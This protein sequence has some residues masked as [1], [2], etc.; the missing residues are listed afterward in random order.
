MKRL[1]AILLFVCILPICAFADGFGL[2][3]PEFI[4]NYN[5]RSSDKPIED[6]RNGEIFGTEDRQYIRLK[7][8]DGVEIFLQYLNSVDSELTGIVIMQKESRTDYEKLISV[9]A[10]VTYVLSHNATD[11]TSSAYY[12]HFQVIC[13]AISYYGYSGKAITSYATGYALQYQIKDG[14]RQMFI[15]PV[16]NK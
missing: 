7:A 16:K 9:A 14:T 8:D 13:E 2:T 5:E 12:Q 6:I 15:A 11:D 1:F 4:Q 10:S 3:I